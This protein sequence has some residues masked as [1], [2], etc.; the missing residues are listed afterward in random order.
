LLRRV[1]D[2]EIQ[3]IIRGCFGTKFVLNVVIKFNALQNM[4]RVRP[5]SI[6]ESAVRRPIDNLPICL[7]DLGRKGR[8]NIDC[9]SKISAEHRVVIWECHWLI[10]KHDPVIESEFTELADIGCLT[11]HHHFWNF[12]L[13][14]EYRVQCWSEHNLRAQS[15][16]PKRVSVHRHEPSFS[17]QPSSVL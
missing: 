6:N 8:A 4:H 2:I 10:T 3:K 5:L 14:D 15:H 16:P 7:E 17:R 12:P 11:R 9:W 13:Q 1:G